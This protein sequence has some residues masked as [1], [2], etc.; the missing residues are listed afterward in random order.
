M[1]KTL[2]ILDLDM[3]LIDSLKVF[4]RVYSQLL[5]K[6]FNEDISFEDFYEKFCTNSLD[7]YKNYPKDFWKDFKEMY[8][9]KDRSEI[10]PI[11][12]AEELLRFLNERGIVVVLSGR[13]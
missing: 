4:Y 8:Y 1:Q 2:Y 6:Y 9:A 12:G 7:N 13:G 10:K 3:T 11:D 5:K